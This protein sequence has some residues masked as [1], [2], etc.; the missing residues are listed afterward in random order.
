M[1]Q[2]NDT[3]NS[4]DQAT[5]K[6]ASLAS[7][8]ND[9]AN[10]TTS[11]AV[12]LQSAVNKTSFDKA[13]KSRIC[14]TD[15]IF[16]VNKLKS[17]HIAFKNASFAKCKSGHSFTVTN[18]HQCNLGKWIDANESSEFAKSKEWDELKVSHARVHSMVQDTVDLY[19]Q[20]YDNQQIFAVT[21]N[22]EVNIEKV[23]DLLNTVR[24]IN[25]KK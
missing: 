5:Q 18:D 15:M 7:N 12:Q 17:D 23:F 11:L 6:N 20:D 2:I 8:I 1:S 14:D 24:E 3:V 16:D 22:L 9:M 10:I 19:A 13:A 21:Q 4:L 25:C